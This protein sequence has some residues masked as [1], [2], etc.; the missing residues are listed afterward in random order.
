MMKKY[1]FYTL[2]VLTLLQAPFAA[3]SAQFDE[4]LLAIQHEWAKANYQTQGDT[5][6]K[7][8]ETLTQKTA[9]FVSANPGSAEALI[10]DGIVNSTYAGA[11][12]G[13]GALK[14]AK[15]ARKDFEAAIKI[16]PNALD[17][18]A[19]TSLGSLYYK[20]PGFP[21]G[22]GSNKK[23]N[24]HLKK[25]LEINPDGIDSN[26]FYGDFL[27]DRKRYGEAIVALN[28]AK[29]AADRPNRP[30]ADQGRRAEI[31]KAIVLAK[32]KK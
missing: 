2:F 32:S 1:F 6:K 24:Q 25:A 15:K 8:L 14:Y 16:N 23:A 18:S 27:I 13:A 9:A 31:D 11:R 5:K 19:H 21:I 10:W 30:I 28:K 29:A 20:V 4:Q 26:Y 3:I 22:F 17:G 12:G 7:A